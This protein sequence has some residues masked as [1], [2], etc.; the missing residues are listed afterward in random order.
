[1]DGTWSID[2]AGRFNLVRKL[3]NDIPYTVLVPAALLLGL[4]P[5]RPEP[6]LVQKL[7]MLIQGTL[8]QPIDIFDLFMHSAPS[9]L[10]IG[11]LA[12]PRP[13]V[14]DSD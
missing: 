8:V 1:M 9:L 14:K 6:H 10:L 7:R 2:K 13:A 11:K 3:L 5:F 12:L 4:A